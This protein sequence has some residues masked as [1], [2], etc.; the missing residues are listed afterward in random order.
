MLGWLVDEDVLGGVGKDW[1][2]GDADGVDGVVLGWL[3]D[4]D[5]VFIDNNEVAEL[6][7]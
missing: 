3:V 4:G 5:D 2:G 7:E 1:G 6:P